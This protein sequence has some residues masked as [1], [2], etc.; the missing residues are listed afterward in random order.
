MSPGPL[1][2]T[3][4]ATTFARAAGSASVPPSSRGLQSLARK[5]ESRASMPK[6][7]LGSFSSSKRMTKVLGW[8]ARG[9][10]R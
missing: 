10:G 6:F 8:K 2:N 4:G 7:D 5:T 1:W 9:Q 3:A